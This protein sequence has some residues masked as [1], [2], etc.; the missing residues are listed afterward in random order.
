MLDRIY[1]KLCT[2]IFFYDFTCK[3]TTRATLCE[4]NPYKDT[5]SFK[6]RLLTLVTRRFM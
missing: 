6:L 4:V 3:I 2:R 5:M 1:K